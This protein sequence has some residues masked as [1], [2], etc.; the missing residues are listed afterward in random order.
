MYSNLTYSDDGSNFEYLIAPIRVLLVRSQ[1]YFEE[2]TDPSYPSLDENITEFTLKLPIFEN[3]GVPLDALVNELSR[4]SKTDFFGHQILYRVTDSPLYVFA[5]I[6]PFENETVY[7]PVLDISY[8]I[9]IK[10]RI[11]GKFT[12]DPQVQDPIQETHKAKA[13]RGNERIIGDVIDALLLWKHLYTVGQETPQGEFMK[14]TRED[15]AR[16]LNIPK[17]TLDDYSAQVKL[18]NSFGFDFQLNCREKFGVLRKF[19][20]L[21]LAKKTSNLE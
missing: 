17:K 19:N 13:R 12:R 3:L 14:R 11:A 2:Q 18:A 5:G 4:A 20:K 21:M 8:P 16:L 7:V 1:I 6:F 9:F 10:C 15:A